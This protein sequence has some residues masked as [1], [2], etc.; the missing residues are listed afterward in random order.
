MTSQNAFQ[1]KALRCATLAPLELV[2]FLL[3]FFFPLGPRIR[4]G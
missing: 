3:L 2:V 4:A 1:P